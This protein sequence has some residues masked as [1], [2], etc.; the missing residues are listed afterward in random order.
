M[1]LI[2]IP[3]LNL[4]GEVSQDTSDTSQPGQRPQTGQ[5]G[6]SV[7]WGRAMASSHL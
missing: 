2:R 5:R 6:A 1:N 3:D 7:V 4:Q